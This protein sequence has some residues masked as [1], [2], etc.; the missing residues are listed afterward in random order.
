MKL[1][2]EHFLILTGLGY[3][4]LS[5][6]YF[7]VYLANYDSFPLL[8]PIQALSESKILKLDNAEKFDPSLS[9]GP[10][11]YYGLMFITSCVI[12]NENESTRKK[13]LLTDETIA[14]GFLPIL[15]A[16]A[17]HFALGYKQF[18]TMTL[19]VLFMVITINF[20]LHERE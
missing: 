12:W 9:W 10:S 7:L 14:T 17:L 19:A 6:S 20:F 15:I 2:T 11:A 4:I 8:E 1:T 16:I 18:F 3:L 5:A 13:D